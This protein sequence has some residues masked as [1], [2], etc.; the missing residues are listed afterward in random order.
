L[1]ITTPT[2]RSELIAVVDGLY[3]L[4]PYSIDLQSSVR[5]AGFEAIVGIDDYTAADK[6]P[7]SVEYLRLY[8]GGDEYQMEGC[9]VTSEEV[10]VG[11]RCEIEFVS[12]TFKH[13]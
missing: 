8:M 10:I 5:N 4:N 7:E 9:Y 12:N 2:S 11:E 3:V 1:S 6:I 13:V